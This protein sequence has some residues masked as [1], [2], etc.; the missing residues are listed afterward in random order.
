MKKYYLFGCI[1]L[2]TLYFSCKNSITSSEPEILTAAY[3][4]KSFGETER[5]F[6]VYVVVDKLPESAKI[7]SIVLKNKRFEKLNYDSIQK[8]KIEINQ[9]L[10]IQSF[11]IQNFIPPMADERA[12][13][14]EFDIEGRLLFIETVFKLK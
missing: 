3:S 5:G 6:Q 12:D 11:Q 9:Y 10:P 14:I 4:L 1:V 8:Q 7:N 13:G 2:M